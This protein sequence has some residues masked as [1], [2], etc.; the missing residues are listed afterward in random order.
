MSS[1]M[2]MPGPAACISAHLW[3]FLHLKFFQPISLM[4][5][6]HAGLMADDEARETIPLDANCWADCLSFLSYRSCATMRGVD[7]DC[8]Q[9]RSVWLS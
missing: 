3:R 1:Y 7:S 2:P 9:K 6:L 5:R 8:S 4:P